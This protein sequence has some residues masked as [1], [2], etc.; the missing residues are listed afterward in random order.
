MLELNCEPLQKGEHIAHAAIELRTLSCQWG[1]SLNTG[2]AIATIACRG[3]PEFSE[4]KIGETLW[5]PAERS[6]WIIMLTRP[7]QT[8]VFL[9][10]INAKKQC[11]AIISTE[12]RVPWQH[13]I[14]L[15]EATFQRFL[16]LWGAMQADWENIGDHVVQFKWKTLEQALESDRQFFFWNSSL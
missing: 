1:F 5:R 9:T 4:I 14:Q 8:S 15:D 3:K 10:I 11:S 6:N 12:D 13:S 2:D 16:A 7:T